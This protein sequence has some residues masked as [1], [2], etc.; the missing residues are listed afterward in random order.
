[1]PIRIQRKR[2]AECAHCGTA[3]VVADEKGYC[4]SVCRFWAKVKKGSGC[5]LWL[6]IPHNSKGYGR[7][8]VAGRKW[9][10]HRF[11]YTFLVG[12]IDPGL[13]LDHLCRNTQC[14]NPAHLD[15]VTPEEHVRRTDQGAHN[16]RKRHCP[17]GHPY[18]LEN[19]RWSGGR[20]HC[21]ACNSDGLG[22]KG[23]RNGNSKLTEALV[24]E[25]RARRAAGEQVLALA[26][27]YGVAQSVMSRAL[28]GVTWSHG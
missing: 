5:W 13:E 26:A 19:T 20:R 25:A 8:T 3:P 2:T 10:A 7:I 16:R 1:M 14:V 6:G 24:I 4:S 27:D 21:R 22:L 28:T 9:L 12:P 18:D 11:A 17:K 15:P 23:A